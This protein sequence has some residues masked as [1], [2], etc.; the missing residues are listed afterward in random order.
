MQTLGIT[1]A[2]PRPENRLKT[3]FWPSIRND[4][5]LD[6]LTEQGFWIC[7]ILSVF[8]EG[9]S[10]LTRHPFLGLFDSVFFYL[11]GFGMRMRSRAAA[12][13]A[14]TTVYLLSG[15]VLQISIGQG[16]DFLKI[17]FL[18]LLLA[19]IRGMWLASPWPKTNAEPPAVQLDATW[20][21]KLSDQ[22]P[23]AIWPR[24]EWLFYILA[25]LEVAGLLFQLFGIVR[26]TIFRLQ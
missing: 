26:P 16:F 4:V 17:V 11:A 12:I 9:V 25:M 20:R 18:A 15:V 22:W 6:N 13:L 1:D 10:V 14:F 5:D 3:L 7:L 19:N 24:L 8:S 21:D 2:T 23:Q